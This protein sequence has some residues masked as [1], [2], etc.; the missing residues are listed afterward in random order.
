VTPQL[1][2]AALKTFP[3][4]PA[5]DPAFLNC[6]PWGVARQMFAPHQL[7]IRQRGDHIDMRYGEWA[8][9][10]TIYLSPGQGNQTVSS[11]GYSVGRYE[12]DTLVIETTRISPNWTWSFQHSGRLKLT[13]RYARSADG[14]RLLLAA[15]MEDPVMLR[16]PIMLKKVWGWSPKSAITPYKNC[17]RPSEL[18]TRW[19]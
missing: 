9:R 10:R 11:M 19:K 14:K 17:E 6:E 16:E 3:P 12:G 1:T 5:K 13:E 4:D 2:A 7:E 8:A 18:F 15:T